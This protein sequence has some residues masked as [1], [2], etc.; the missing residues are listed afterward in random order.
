M[1]PTVFLWTRRKSQ[2]LLSQPQLLAPPMNNAFT[3]K[4]CLTLAQSSTHRRR[5]NI[6]QPLPEKL[7]PP[8]SC[9]VSA[10]GGEWGRLILDLVR[11]GAGLHPHVDLGWTKGQDSSAHISQRG[12]K[13]CV[14]HE[15]S[16]C[17]RALGTTLSTLQL[18][19]LISAL[20]FQPL[21]QTRRQA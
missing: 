2:D 13:A 19:V 6:Q 14:N 21:C 18:G 20:L 9:L 8:F 12:T 15:S 11:K 7:P 17:D 5:R 3:G 16:S 1:R 4:S 10:L